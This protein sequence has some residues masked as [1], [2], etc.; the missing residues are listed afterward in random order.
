MKVPTIYGEM[1]DSELTI[2]T[3]EEKGDGCLVVATEWRTKDGELVRRDG[4]LII[5]MAPYGFGIG[6]KKGL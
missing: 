3:T 5:L 6:V 2:K 4:H 1:D